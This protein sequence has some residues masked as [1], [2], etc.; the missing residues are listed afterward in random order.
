MLRTTRVDIPN[1]MQHIIVRGHNVPV[2]PPPGNGTDFAASFS[3][4]RRDWLSPG[5]GAGTSARQNRCHGRATCPAPSSDLGQIALW[6]D[7]NSTS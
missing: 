5:A 3:S 4:F 6:T 7:Q 1:L 2:V